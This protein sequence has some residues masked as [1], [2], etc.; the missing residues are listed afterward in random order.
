MP[1]SQRP[2]LH[3][4]FLLSVPSW[5]LLVITFVNDLDSFTSSAALRPWNIALIS[6]LGLWLASIVALI[7]SRYGIV[8]ASPDLALSTAGETT[9]IMLARIGS[10]CL[11]PV[12]AIVVGLHHA[13]DGDVGLVT[14]SCLLIGTITFWIGLRLATRQIPI[15]Q[16]VRIGLVWVMRLSLVTASMFAICAQ[17]AIRSRL[18]WSK[19]YVVLI[20][21]FNNTNSDATKN[22]S[23]VVNDKIRSEL[24]ARIKDRSDVQIKPIDE[25][26][27]SKEEAWRRGADYGAAIVIWG[28]YLGKDTLSGISAD[29]NAH[30]ETLC[31][32]CPVDAIEQRNKEPRLFRGAEGFSIELALTEEFSYLN[33]FVLGMIDYQ[34]KRYSNSLSEFNA[35]VE[36]K[37]AFIKIP[38]IEQSMVLY[39][40]GIA[41]DN[42]KQSELAN[43]DLLTAL[44]IY[45]ANALAANYYASLLYSEK[46][47]DG[48]IQYYDQALAHGADARCQYFFQNRGNAYY[49]ARRYSEALDNYKLGLG[50][51]GESPIIYRQLGITFHALGNYPQALADLTEAI[52]LNKNTPEAYIYADRAATHR[53]LGE[54]AQAVDDLNVAIQLS[55]KQPDVSYYDN[56]A[57]NYDSLG[58]LTQAIDDRQQAASITPTAE[59][60]GSLGRILYRNNQFIDALAAFDQAL[61]L[62]P[63]NVPYRVDHGNTQL[64]LNN[65][66]QAEQDLRTAIAADPSYAQAYLS[67]STALQRRKD[68]DGA[69]AAYDKA[70][71]YEPNL[72]ETYKLRSALYERRGDLVN[73][74]A[75]AQHWTELAPDNG[76]AFFAYGRL[77]YDQKQYAA[78]LEPLGK[79]SSLQ[80]SPSKAFYY[81]ALSY[82]AVGDEANTFIHLSA[83]IAAEP[84][85]VDALVDR[86]EIYRRRADYVAARH[87]LGAGLAATTDAA[88]Q[89][90]IKAKLAALP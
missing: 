32:R 65:N 54:Y 25:N 69:F 11:L 89:E 14:S 13:V 57:A 5:A 17:P 39:Y 74:T 15:V 28:D 23:L 75:D 72:A 10:F 8:V 48:A 19:S 3:I 68:F 27:T 80:T 61:R 1:A 51:T 53:A 85:F 52:E 43:N 40:R 18:P 30:F 59:R 77:L 24:T 76:E 36:D 31:L 38:P 21:H 35:L 79:A 9:A 22:T 86:A 33:R 44:Q 84:A 50:A 67:L 82:R 81:R 16:N 41:Y 2:P 58:Q 29:V 34:A 20:A 66:D 45:P 90:T 7:R 47:Y 6:T 70:R 56:R 37:T 87:D 63:E 26:F 46:N 62:E 49:M 73:A 88:K 83:A 12:T 64:Q 60:Y 42:L 4:A 78:A 71:S 55:E